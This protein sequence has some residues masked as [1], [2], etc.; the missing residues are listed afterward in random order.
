MKLLAIFDDVTSSRR[1]AVSIRA[2]RRSNIFNVIVGTS[3]PGRGGPRAREG[4]AAAGRAILC[5]SGPWKCK[6]RVETLIGAEKNDFRIIFVIK[7]KVK[8]KKQ[9]I[10]VSPVP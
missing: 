8:T 3:G 1:R 7:K 10:A 2:G 6:F 4:E 5:P 9:K